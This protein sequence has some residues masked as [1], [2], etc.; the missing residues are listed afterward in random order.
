[1][2]DAA[3][4]TGAA[5]PA[6]PHFVVLDGLRRVAAVMAVLVHLFGAYAQNVPQKQIVN[7]G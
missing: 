7:P 6:K 2:A 3:T 5:A 4:S 1:M